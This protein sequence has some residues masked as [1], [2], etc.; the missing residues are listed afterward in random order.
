MKTPFKVFVTD[1][2][3]PSLRVELSI[4]EPVG[5]YLEWFPEYTES[6]LLKA[7]SSADAI[8]TCW[9]QI[10]E[11]ALHAAPECKVIGRYGIGLD[12]IPVDL[13]TELGILVTNVPPVLPR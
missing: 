9:N 7:V 5:A 3:W 6:C 2:V 8:L 13:A 1:F 11:A 12:N 4:L 10:P